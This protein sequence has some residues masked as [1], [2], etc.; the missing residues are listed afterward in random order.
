DG[1]R[2]SHPAACGG[3]RIRGHDAAGRMVERSLERRRRGCGRRRRLD[4]RRRMGRHGVDVRRGRSLE[5]V[6]TLTGAPYQHLGF[7]ETCDAAPWAIVST[8]T[9]GGLFARTWSGG[10]PSETPLS[11]ALLGSPHRYRIDWTE[12]GVTYSV[13]GTAVTTDAIAITTVM[14]PLISDF[15]P[16]DGA[17]SVDWIRMTPYAGTAAFFS[18]IVDP[19]TFA[20][21]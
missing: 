18:R 12:T 1:E 10:T 4:R 13:D 5:F 15:T 2:R 7:G 16:G 6:A 21:C 8:G 20:N 11:S 14:R 3:Q 9:G 19:T 17:L